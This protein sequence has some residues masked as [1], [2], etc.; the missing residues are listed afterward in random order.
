M[1]I[2]WRV[3]H[4]SRSREDIAEGAAGGY[5]GGGWMGGLEQGT[6]ESPQ[7]GPS[8]PKDSPRKNGR[9]GRGQEVEWRPQGGPNASARKG[10]GRGLW[11]GRIEG[12]KMCKQI[13]LR[14]LHMRTYAHVRVGLCNG[15]ESTAFGEP[16][17]S[18][19]CRPVDIIKAGCWPGSRRFGRV[20]S[21]GFRSGNYAGDERRS[22]MDVCRFD[23]GKI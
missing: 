2:T 6:P 7:G 4:L 10:G 1:Y 19:C 23:F 14:P 15:L 13:S 21:A 17:A 3:Y 20:F 22:L 12:A 8:D 9:G 18:G 5:M 16:V 11:G